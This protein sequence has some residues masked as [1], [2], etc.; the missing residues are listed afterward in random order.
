MQPYHLILTYTQKTLACEFG[1]KL[2]TPQLQKWA[3]DHQEP[4][5]EWTTAWSETSL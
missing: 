4:E 1:V 5:N 3:L 2:L